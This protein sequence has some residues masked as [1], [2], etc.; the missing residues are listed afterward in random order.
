MQPVQIEES[1][2]ETTRWRDFKTQH[3]AI[4]ASCNTYAADL[5]K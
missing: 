1:T 4:V 2:D 3:N 5:I